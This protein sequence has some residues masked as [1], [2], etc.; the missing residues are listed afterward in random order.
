MFKI[1]RHTEKCPEDLKSFAVTQT[2]WKNSAYTDVKNSQEM[3]VII[4]KN[5]NNKNNNNKN[6][7]NNNSNNNN[8]NNNN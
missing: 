5:N 1:G 3:I 8:N 4:I 7:N 2:P 6:N